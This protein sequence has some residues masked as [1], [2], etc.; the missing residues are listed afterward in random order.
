[1]PPRPAL[2]QVLDAVKGLDME[3]VHAQVAKLR[4]STSTVE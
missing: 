4:P 3:E 2:K 1:V